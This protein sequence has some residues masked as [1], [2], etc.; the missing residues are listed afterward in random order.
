MYEK[1]EA[2]GWELLVTHL[3]A[4]WETCNKLIMAG[5]VQEARDT[6]EYATRVCEEARKV[7]EED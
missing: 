5:E 1:L 7:R 4:V 3:W 6:C 2:E